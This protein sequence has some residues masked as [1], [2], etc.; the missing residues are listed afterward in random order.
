MVLRNSAG[1]Y[2]AF[3]YRTLTVFGRPFQAVQLAGSCSL[4][5]IKGRQILQPPPHKCDGFGLFPVRSPLLGES[6]LISLPP[7]TEM[8]HF[9]GLS[10]SSYL[11]CLKPGPL[12]E[13][14]RRYPLARFPDSEIP[15]SGDVCS[16]PGLIAAYHVL[17]RLPTPR[18]SSYALNA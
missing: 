10:S 15:G 11:P 4:P 18:H 16:S 1:S 2:L 6:R 5:A 17:L 9:S 14:G 13:D 3:A 8:F 12:L 7:D